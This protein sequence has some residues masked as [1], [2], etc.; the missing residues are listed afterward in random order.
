MPGHPRR[1]RGPARRLRRGGGRSRRASRSRTRS[2]PGPLAS[3]TARAVRSACAGGSSGRSRRRCGSPW[4]PSGPG[5][6]RGACAGRGAPPRRRPPRGRRR[7]IHPATWSA[8]RWIASNA[9]VHA[10]GTGGSIPSS[11]V[12]NSRVGAG[13]G[14]QD[15]QHPAGRDPP[16]HRVDGGRLLAREPVERHAADDRVERPVGHGMS[17]TP[18][19]IRST[20]GARRAS[21]RKRASI[22]SDGSTPVAWRVPKR[23][24]I[25]SVTNPV[26]QP[27]SRIRSYR[28]SGIAAT[29]RRAPSALWRSRSS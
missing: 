12:L 21:R 28:P 13:A 18:A 4:R 5:R 17:W 2:P 20:R 19:V 26:P 8:V 10:T 7:A 3:C 9:P 14:G 22:P 23:S 29:R 16:R 6:R 1:E 11:T 15:R 25:A 24:A 27:T